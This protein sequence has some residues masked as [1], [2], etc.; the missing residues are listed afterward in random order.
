MV[1][2]TS[3]RL[4]IC[5]H[6]SKSQDGSYGLDTTVTLEINGTKQRVRLCGARSGLPP[7]LIV[8]AGPGV[9]LLNESA[10]F[11]Q[12]LQ[13]EQSFS[14]AYW[15]QR[16]CG[17]AALQDAQN[18]SLETQI[19]DLCAV[20]RWLAEEIQQQVVVLG[21]S[22]GATIALQAAAREASNIKALVAASIDADTSASDTAAYSFMQEAST[23]ADKRKIAR[24]I[25]KLGAP[26][27]STPT[28]FQLRARILADLGCIEHGK[29]FGELLRSL[30]Y[31]L[32]RTYGWFGAVAALRNMNA[33]QRKLLPEL[34]KVNLFANWP[35]LA[36]PVHY[37]FG[38]GDPLVPCSMVQRVSDVIADSDTV[39]TLPD[40]G[41]MVHFDKPAIVRSII[42]Q[43]HSTP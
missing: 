27:Y 3:G 43:A 26:P 41:H 8:Q 11:Q 32:I 24:L 33:I 2:T 17:Q 30:L 28:P 37:I 1:T 4:S 34:A 10:K 15:D 39:V 19:N 40:A 31:S 22:L 12:L 18:L 38:G 7:V 16:G 13:L 9:P 42:A 21:I 25:K 6:H 5:R 35:R 20:V 36:I 23:Q 14:V 29:R